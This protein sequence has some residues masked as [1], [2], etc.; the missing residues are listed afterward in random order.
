MKLSKKNI[1]TIR[2]GS[3]LKQET[4][5][6]LREMDPPPSQAITLF[7]TQIN[8]QNG[9]PF[10]TSLLTTKTTFDG[11]HENHRNT[12]TFINIDTLFKDLE[13]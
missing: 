13:T 8:L 9:L 1:L 7:H 10:Q 5:K 12:K 2:L 6:L 4:E 11:R 3:V